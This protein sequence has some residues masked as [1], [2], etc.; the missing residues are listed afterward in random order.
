MDEQMLRR[1][2]MEASLERFR[3]VLEGADRD[4]NWSPR[5]LRSRTRLL[6]DPFGWAKRMARPVWKR[7]VRAAA[8]AALACLVTL[9]G[10]MAVSPTVRAAVLGWLREI[11]E[12]GI[13]YTALGNRDGAEDHEPPDWMLT[14]LPEG[15]AL[16]SA[17]DLGSSAEKQYRCGESW[18]RFICS[19]PDEGTI[20]W[21]VGDPE[22]GESRR[23]VTVN[24]YTAE[25]YGDEYRAMLAWQDEDGMLF[26]FT[27][28]H[29]DPDALVEMA[30]SAAPE[31]TELP[32]Y[33]PTW[34]PEGYWLDET[35][36]GGGAALESIWISADGND[37]LTLLCSATPLTLPEEEAE[38]VEVQGNAAQF[39][40]AEEPHEDA[41]RQ[42]TVGGESVEGNTVEVGGVT[43]I[44]GSVA[45]S[46]ST[47]A[48]TLAW[49]NSEGIYFRLHG[50]ESMGTLLRVAASITE[51]TEEQNTTDSFGG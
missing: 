21:G 33:D 30:A 16:D 24:G 7:A 10:L 13:F 6:A 50:M 22:S 36:G 44:V 14:D 51:A 26:Y 31:E 15:W 39:W 17:S 34:L 40:A 3:D 20:G 37:S 19:Y 45:G 49:Q 46:Q 4:W 11:T 5:Y 8:C 12:N 18:V 38:D 23:E 25:L 32:F 28:A 48:G 29:V 1:A 43:I 2:L 42:V 27:S 41:D 47:D 9:G 35:T